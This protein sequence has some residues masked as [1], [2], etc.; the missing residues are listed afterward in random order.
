MK[1]FS[2]RRNMLKELHPATQAALAA[3][4]LIA[5]LYSSNPFLQIALIVGIGILF[6]STDSFKKWLWWLKI[7]SVIGIVAIAIN[8]LVSRE[9]ETL[10]WKGILI[11]AFGRIDITLEA[12]VYGTGMALRLSAVILAFAL[13]SELLDADRALG[14][15]KSGLRSALL[16]ALSIRLVPTLSRDSSEILD[17][18]RSRGIA[19]D[20]GSKRSI[21]RSRMPLVRKLLGTALDRA[22]GI[23]E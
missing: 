23:A 18:Q 7:C 22:V 1:P 14:M 11:P 5:S 15:L 17:A 2:K 6:A 16:T 13:L 19:R 9:G 12:I 8:A 21:A 4:I 10:L 3:L 20:T